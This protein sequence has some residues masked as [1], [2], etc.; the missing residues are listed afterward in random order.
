[1][2]SRGVPLTCQAIAAIGTAEYPTKAVRPLNSRL[3]LERLASTYGLTP[4]HWRTALDPVLDEYVTIV[5]AE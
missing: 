4:P 2:R 1:L 3:S 5:G